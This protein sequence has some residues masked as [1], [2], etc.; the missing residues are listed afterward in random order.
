MIAITL[1]DG[2]VRRFARRLT[3]AEIARRSAPASRAPRWR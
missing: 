1:P 3:G 2:S